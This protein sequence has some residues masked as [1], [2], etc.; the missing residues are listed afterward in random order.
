MAVADLLGGIQ[1]WA[2]LP[3]GYKTQFI[4][5]TALHCDGLFSREMAA[6]AGHFSQFR[7]L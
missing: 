7:C 2:R 6:V 5:G 1:E 4:K 3:L